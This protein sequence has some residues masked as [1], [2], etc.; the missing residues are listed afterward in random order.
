[1]GKVAVDVRRTPVD[2]LSATGH[3]VYGPKG[4]GFLYAREGTPVAPMLH[5]GGQERALRPGTQDVAGAVGLATAVRLAVDEQE[6]SAARMRMLRARLER[7]L[8]S[9]LEGVRI[10]AGQASRAPHVLSVGVGG[11]EDGSAL[12]MALDLEGIAV[13][14]GSACTSGSMKAS[15]VMRALYG[16]DDPHATV[17]YSFGRETDEADIDTALSATVTVVR[18]MREA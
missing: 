5:G 11:I 18:R 7:G 2:L 13:S 6:A 10:N 17:R 14:G 12:V 8:L 9:E 15:H 3:K 16:P 1:L 4:T